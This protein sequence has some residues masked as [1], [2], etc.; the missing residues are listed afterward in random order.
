MHAALSLLNK[1][2]WFKAGKAQ[3]RPIWQCSKEHDHQAL[4]KKPKQFTK[5][6]MNTKEE[7]GMNKSSHRI[8]VSAKLLL[9]WSL[10]QLRKCAVHKEGTD[11]RKPQGIAA[12]TV[13]RNQYTA[14]NW[15]KHVKAKDRRPLT[16]SRNV[17]QILCISKI[18]YKGAFSSDT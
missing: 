5:F 9:F 2:G 17:L 7:I 6:H 14:R 10:M 15:R 12:A 13:P 1:I 11:N 4:I 16:I 3:T 8:F 18:T